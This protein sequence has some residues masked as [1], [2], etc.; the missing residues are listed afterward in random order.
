MQCQPVGRAMIM[1]III[2]HV[3]AAIDFVL[4]WSY[5]HLIYVKHGQT[6]VDKYMAFCFIPNNLQIS[7]AIID[8]ISTICADSAMVL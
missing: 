5:M 8:I 6:I 3:M 2:I 7:I 4:Q 1:V